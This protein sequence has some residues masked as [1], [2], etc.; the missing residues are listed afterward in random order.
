MKLFQAGL[1]SISL[2]AF[3]GTGWAQEDSPTATATPFSTPLVLKP[4]VKLSDGDHR[5]LPRAPKK[6]P[7]G[8]AINVDTDDHIPRGSLMDKLADS[9][10][11]TLIDGFNKLDTK[12]QQANWH[13]INGTLYCHFRDGDNDWYGWRTGPEFHW[14]L[15][16]GGLFWFHDRF[17]DRWL[18]YDQGTWWWQVEDKQNPIQVL[19]E[20][21][22]YYACDGKG[23]L[24]SN[25]GTTGQ[26]EVVTK[27]IVKET[28]V[29]SKDENPA[30]HSGMGGMS[31]GMGMKSY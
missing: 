26:E 14:V 1:F 28:P 11:L 22:H 23:V 8:K 2:L 25:L 20:D 10:A 21:N 29:S 30:E 16:R 13:E 24:G 6:G 5:V 12:S 4:H 27:P 18:Y 17:A 9:A 31:P 3:F 15:S 7:T 19:L